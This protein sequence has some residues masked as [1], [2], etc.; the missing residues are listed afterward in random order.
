LGSLYAA[1]EKENPNLAPT[2]KI[3]KL[4]LNLLQENE[5]MRLKTLLLPQL[6]QL[7]KAKKQPTFWEL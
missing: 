5:Q 1:S 2:T 4:G 6:T 3:N 7:V